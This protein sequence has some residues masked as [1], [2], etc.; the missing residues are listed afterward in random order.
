MMIIKTDER[1]NEKNIEIEQ[2]IQ[3][4]KKWYRYIWNKRKRNRAGERDRSEEVVC[5][6]RIPNLRSNKIETILCMDAGT[7][8]KVYTAENTLQ[9]NSDNKSKSFVI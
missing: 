5:T 1:E 8:P 9:L 6:F 7:A 3:K 4:Q 2:A